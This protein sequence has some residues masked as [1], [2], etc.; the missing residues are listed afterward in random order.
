MENIK[1]ELTEEK[2][3]EAVFLAVEE[4]F[5]SSY[6]N[7]FVD[8]IQEELKKE[9]S[10]FRELFSSVIGDIMTNP[11]FKKQLGELAM[12]SLIEKALKN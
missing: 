5:K 1:I 11:G 8:I 4:V 3:K 2:L 9:D 12:K 10:K 6:R 7:P